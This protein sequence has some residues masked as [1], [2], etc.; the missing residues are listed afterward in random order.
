MTAHP[1]TVPHDH[2]GR[3]A[4]TLVRANPARDTWNVL[5]REL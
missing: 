5:T 2:P 3:D 1:A 4:D